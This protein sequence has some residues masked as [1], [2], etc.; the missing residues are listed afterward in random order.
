[1]GGDG[2]PRV[3]KLDVDNYLSWATEMENVMRYKRCW[4][5]IN[6]LEGGASSS[7]ASA[8]GGGTPAVTDEAAVNKE[9]MA[10]SLI[11]LNVRQHHYASLHACKTA[12]ERWETLAAEFRSQGPAREMILR[13]ELNQVRMKGNEN[14]VQYFNRSKLIVWELGVLGV[15]VADRQHLTA[16]LHGLGPKL[17]LRGTIIASQRAMTVALALEELRAAESEMRLEAGTRKE[18]S[19]AAMAA[20]DGGGRWGAQERLCFKCNKPGHIKRNCPE[21]DKGR[22]HN[23]EKRAVAMLAHAL[24]AGAGEMDVPG[25][26]TEAVATSA[27]RAEGG[28]GDL[29]GARRWIVDSGASHH[30][31]GEDT[32]LTN[33]GPCDP[34]HVALAD[35]RKRVAIKMGTAV[36]QGIAGAKGVDLTLNDVLVVPGLTVSLFSVRVATKLG[37]E[38]TFRADGMGVY[39]RSE[40]LVDGQRS[41]NIY[42]LS[43]EGGRL[44]VAATAASA[45]TWHQRFAHAGGGTMATVPAAV[46]GMEVTAAELRNLGTAGCEPCIRG[47]MTRQPFDTSDTVVNEP[48]ELLHTDVGGPMPIPT[49]SGDRFEVVIVDHKS[50]YKVV[51]PVTSK[52]QATNVVN[53]WETQLGRKAKVVRCDGGKEYTGK[54]FDQWRSEKGIVVQT[55]TRYTPEQNGVAERYNRTLGERVTAVLADSN[56]PR[57]WWGE[58]ALTVTYVANRTPT[59][60]E[61]ATPYE[62]FFGEKPDV[63]H[64][65]AFGCRV[66]AHVPHQVRREMGDKAKMG[67]F[68]GYGEDTKGYKVLLNGRIVLSRDVRFNEALRGPEAIAGRTPAVS[69]DGAAGS[70]P[71]SEDPH[72][73]GGPS[74]VEDADLGAEDGADD[75]R[76]SA[77]QTGAG[78][79][80]GDPPDHTASKAIED[81]VDAARRLCPQPS[82]SDEPESDGGP[83]AIEDSADSGR[84]DAPMGGAEP[85]GGLPSR[86]SVRSLRVRPTPTARDDMAVSTG[87]S[88]AA[89]SVNPDKM[90]I[91]QARREPDWEQFNMAVEAEV[92]S[93]W[94]NGTWEL[95]DLPPGAKVTG[96]QM[97]CE[98]KRGADGAVSRHKAR[99][100]ARGDT[101]VYLVDYSEVWA[102]VARHATLRAVLAA[103]AGNGWALCQLDVETA[104][105]N[106]VVEEE[107]YVREPTGYERGSCGKVCRLL[108]ALYGLKQASRAWYKK[109]TAVLREAGMRATEADPCL[110]FGSFGAVLVFVLVYVDDLLVAGASEEA[111]AMC[112]HV[113]TGAFTVRDLGVPK[114]FLGMHISHDRKEGLLSLGQRQYVTTVLERFGLGDSNPVRLPMGT[115]VV[116]QRE[117]TPLEPLMA[118]KY[119]E[120][121]GSLLYLATC[122]RPD[123]SFAVGKLSRHVSAPTQ[124]HWAAAKT[125]MR[126]L[127]GT[128]DWRIIYGAKRPLVGYSDADYAG[129]VDTRRSTTGQAFLWGGGAISWGSKIQ[130]TV[131]ASTTEAEYVAAAMA[132]KEAIWLQRLVRE[133]GAGG[134]PVVMHCDSQGAIALMRNPTSSN[135]TKHIDVAHH[136]VRE[137]VDG[138]AIKVVAVGTADMVADC[139]TKPLPTEAFNKCRAALGLTDGEAGTARVGVLAPEPDGGR[140]QSRAGTPGPPPAAPDVG[141]STPTTTAA[142]A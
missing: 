7:S 72:P 76:R 23:G 99:Y 86:S 40:L 126:Y 139:L 35:G 57:K 117:G 110:F 30:M 130:A 45:H 75:G 88:Y 131:A 90:L 125:V 9:E 107:V 60:G 85:G 69:R 136:F 79:S 42:V 83:D 121:V 53:R 98:R 118:T 128:R 101:Q 38:V 114:Y 6:P 80:T 127:Q 31:T 116:L 93:L 104:F 25:S 47:K 134:E 132:A 46:T 119:Q 33:L 81:A 108:K 36:I 68:M 51:V 21:W 29:G 34:V 27:F 37:Y 12:R 61:T 17:K 22:K 100:V 70:A 95:V 15:E 111:V 74:E 58:A 123:I 142:S 78:A 20:T 28:P 64:L 59:R 138:G 84:A 77:T 4:S 89:V 16:L 115:G 97:L 52:G 24:P 87:E 19:G 66:W 10:R 106:G 55:T 96:T 48:L 8:D 62:L 141:A 49:P 112:K 82:G 1:M 39:D 129:D 44:A 94:R 18:T 11:M 122:T 50:K 137:C 92:D 41:G 109:L 120:A 103:A 13:T 63:G 124:A 2:V 71:N 105:L 135:R 91:Y 140:T 26:S 56:L 102:P 14:V 43:E 3:P 67:T 5:A 73:L 54:K 133:L 32:V 113:L 65:R